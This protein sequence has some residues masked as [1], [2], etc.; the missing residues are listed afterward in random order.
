MS[1][2]CQV[3]SNL[4]AM[5]YL[6]NSSNALFMITNS[7]AQFMYK[8]VPIYVHHMQPRFGQEIINNLLSPVC[9]VYSLYCNP[10]VNL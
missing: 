9:H 5:T 10:R 7:W 6:F 2:Q 1:S 4:H 3:K 8:D